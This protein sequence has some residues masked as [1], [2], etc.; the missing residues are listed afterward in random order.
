MTVGLNPPQS[1]DQTVRRLGWAGPLLLHFLPNDLPDDDHLKQAL[2]AVSVAILFAFIAPVYALLIWLFETPPT[3]YYGLAVEAFVTAASSL[4][5]SRWGK[6]RSASVALVIGGTIAVL[7]PFLREGSTSTAAGNFVIVIVMAALLLGWK[8]VLALGIPVALLLVMFQIAELRGWFHPAPHLMSGS[9]FALMQVTSLTVMLVIFDRVR[10]GL[11]RARKELEI[12]LREGHRLEAVGRLAGGIAHD[13]NNLLTVILANVELL[14]EAPDA[15]HNTKEDAL[16]IRSAAERAAALTKQLLA[17]SRQ[18]RLEPA[19][20]ELGILLDDVEGMLRR[21]IS[22]TISL[23][24]TRVPREVWLRADP[25][26]VAQVVMN[27]AVNARDA[28]PDGGTLFI[29]AMYVDSTVA[30]LPSS[31]PRGRYVRLSVRDTGIGMDASTRERAF[32]PFFTTKSSG[33]GL[34]LATVHGIIVQSGGAIRVSS[35]SGVGTEFEVFLPSA[36]PPSGVPTKAAE[37]PALPQPADIKGS[38]RTILLVEDN[39]QVRSST[40][41]MLRGQGH[42]VLECTGA[43]EALGYWRTDAGHIDLVLSDVIMPGVSGPALLAAMLQDGAV[44]V[45][46]MSGYL[47]AALDSLPVGGFFIAKPFSARDL[48]RKIHEALAAPSL[49]RTMNDDGELAD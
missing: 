23:Q 15:S 10:V 17:F 4:I 31:L 32:E 24:T 14:I 42:H 3:I 39:D 12:K 20:F 37:S 1:H 13:F 45:V 43:D 26:Q 49:A 34:G 11:L 9:V 6:A 47:D 28:M 35:Q 33:T 25:G 18:Q 38:S 29:S 16:A 2:T 5:L 30:P 7:V 44:R 46:F 36:S 27:L 41:R 21:V 8:G 40:A 19:V 22:E 48:E